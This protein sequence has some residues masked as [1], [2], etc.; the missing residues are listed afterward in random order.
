MANN[1]QIA[2]AKPWTKELHMSVKWWRAQLATTTPSK[3]RLSIDT[4]NK[5]ENALSSLLEERLQ[6]HWHPENPIQGQALRSV[7]LHRHA[8]PDPVLVKA[9]K[10]A[11]IPL[12]SLLS[13]IHGDINELTLFIDPG[14]VAVHTLF[15]YSKSIQETIVWSAPDRSRKTQP[16]TISASTSSPSSAAPPSPQRRDSSE[17][18]SASSSSSSSASSSNLKASAKEYSPPPSPPR[19]SPVMWTHSSPSPATS[20]STS[21]SSRYFKVPISPYGHHQHAFT[22]N[23]AAAFATAELVRS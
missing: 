17:S 20:T 9:A 8:R 10:A 6:G 19:A 21:N 11:A 4:L 18:D 12:K 3:A 5:F 14:E 22:N 23:N 16:S 13:F 7:S 2:K 1:V 15:R